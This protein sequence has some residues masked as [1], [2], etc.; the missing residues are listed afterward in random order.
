MNHQ[1]LD[2]VER[3]GRREDKLLEILIEAQSCSDYNYLS[4]DTLKTVSNLLDIS[5]TKVYGIA[6]FYAMLSTKKRGKHVIQVCH[7]APCHLEDGD[8]LVSIF[9][10]ILGIKI[11]ETTGD[12]L[13][14]LEYTSCIGACDEAPAARIDD[15]VYGLLDRSKVFGILSV[16]RGG[17]THDEVV[18]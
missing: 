17:E 4:E 7:S 9:E 11:G 8:H 1:V 10:D 2:I 14:S 15:I 3:L 18:I 6:E 12:N 16:I 5:F 13:F